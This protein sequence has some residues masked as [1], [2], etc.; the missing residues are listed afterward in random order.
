MSRIVVGVDASSGARSALAWAAKE[1]RLRQ[2][3]LEVVYAYHGRR[4][5]VGHEYDSPDHVSAV[6]P[7]LMG[8]HIQSV[9]AGPAAGEGDEGKA[10]VGSAA[11][12]G[13]L[14]DDVLEG[15]Q[16]EITGVDVKRTVVDDRH[17]AEALLDAGR[18]ADLLVVG[19]RGRGGFSE[20]MLG[21]VSHAVVMHAVCPVVVVPQ[22]DS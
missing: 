15:V 14:L 7:G 2:A 10:R 13:D 20:L 18:Q 16:D 22:R 9:D 12:A 4:R 21:S 11:G 17:P 5:G 19:S 3:T 6:E 8:P 1:A